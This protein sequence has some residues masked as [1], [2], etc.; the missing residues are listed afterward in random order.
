MAFSILRVR[1][2]ILRVGVL[3][4]ALAAILS[5]GAEAQSGPAGTDTVSGQDTVAPPER[6]PAKSSRRPRSPARNDAGPTATTAAPMSIGDCNAL[7]G[8]V[9]RDATGLCKLGL[10]CG[11]TDADGNMH[12]VCITDFSPT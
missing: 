4:L 9:Q 5:F 11:R 6:P 2:P 3:S 1:G 7:S 10:S 12:L 8:R